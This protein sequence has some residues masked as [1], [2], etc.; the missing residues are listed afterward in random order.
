MS[1]H[2][3]ISQLRAL[4]GEPEFQSLFDQL[5]QGE[6]NNTRF[7][8]RMELRRV[9]APCQRVIDLR[10]KGIKRC[11]LVEYK[12]QTH[13]LDEGARR[14]FEAGLKEFSGRYTMGIYEDIEAYAQ[15]VRQER[16]LSGEE[17][18][19]ENNWL[20]LVRFGSLL[21]RDSE[22]MHFAT[23]VII[24]QGGSVE[25]TGSTTDISASGTQVQLSDQAYINPEA[26]LELIF[27]KLTDA[28]RRPWPPL[29]YAL[30]S[31]QENR[32]RLRLKETDPHIKGLLQALIEHHQRRYKLDI[33]HIQETTRSRGFE[34]MLLSHSPTLP[35]FF[36][37]DGEARYCLTTQ[38]NQQLQHQ[39]F[40]QEQSLLPALLPPQRILALM[41]REEGKRETYL[42]CFEHHQQGKVFHFATDL[43]ELATKGMLLSFLRFAVRKPGWRAYKVNL[44]PTHLRDLSALDQDPNAA[45]NELQLADATLAPLPPELQQL[46]SVALLRD[47]TQAWLTEACRAL[48]DVGQDPNALTAFRINFSPGVQRIAMRFN[49]MRIE[50]RYRYKTQV[51]LLF[52]GKELEAELSDFSTQGLC[53]TL[54]NPQEQLPAEL[55]VALPKLQ[56]LSS[57]FDL[58]Q[59]PYRLVHQEQMTGRVHLMIQNTSQAHPAKRFFSQ[60]I[61]AN[62]GRLQPLDEDENSF[63]IARALR[64]NIVASALPSCLFVQKHNGKIKPNWLGVPVSSLPLPRLLSRMSQMSDGHI[65][66]ESLMSQLQFRQLIQDW[67]NSNR[68]D[69]SLLVALDARGLPV[70]SR[71]QDQLPGNETLRFL[72]QAR[73]KGHWAVWLLE[74]ARTPKPDLHFIQEDLNYI[75]RQALH[76]A[77]RLEQDLWGTLAMVEVTDITALA[78]AMLD[79]PN[80]P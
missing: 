49:D 9:A 78:S 26:D 18:E 40:Q 24:R 32:V 17:E 67:K 65:A 59:L 70:V 64:Q 4:V 3:I 56:K 39:L 45:G 74:F 1:K 41:A 63:A 44:Y 7:L 71:L 42:L 47:V 61:N 13:Y 77:K 27:P 52:E 46:G 38:H 16:Q 60:L 8:L 54:A 68:R 22:R 15:S 66:L 53:L 57:R 62:E 28:N 33:R 10:L 20:E 37:Q 25:L 14:I 51:Q 30:I 35:V 69:Q 2:P 80:S 58:M 12:G 36:D 21:T 75:G 19:E 73:D 11:Q 23:P 43:E 5:T 31:Q 29:Q 76:R 79:L 34:Q 48:P 55:D 72:E 6:D 50:P